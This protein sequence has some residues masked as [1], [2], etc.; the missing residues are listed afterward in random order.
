MTGILSQAAQ[1]AKKANLRESEDAPR[2]SAEASASLREPLALIKLASDY[3]LERGCLKNREELAECE[4][5]IRR[6][7]FCMARALNH[8]DAVPRVR[9]SWF[10]LTRLCLRITEMIEYT[11]G[12]RKTRLVFTPP[13]RS[14]MFYGD[15]SLIRR[16][17]LCLIGEATCRSVEDGDED[18]DKDSR[19]KIVRL[20]LSQTPDGGILI[21]I[22]GKAGDFAQNY[23]RAMA[24]AQGGNLFVDSRGGEDVGIII[25][26]PFTDAESGSTDG[27]A[28]EAEFTPHGGMEEILTELAPLVPSEK[29]S[30]KYF[31]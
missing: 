13:Q 30:E 20:R 21:Y 31:D 16:M 19:E 11:L 7:I 23:M 22:T 25:S 15:E 12:F 18:K 1:A 2:L 14:I 26:L 28:S 8:L 5:A 24:R 27:K 9:R 3:M 6:G 17:L 29:F 10:D 4:R